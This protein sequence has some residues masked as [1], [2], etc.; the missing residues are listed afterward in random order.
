MKLKIV[1]ILL[2]ALILCYIGFMNH[3][4]LVYPDTGTY[5][6]SGFSGKVPMERTIFYGLFMRHVSL[7]SSPWLII[8]AQGAFV[9]YLLYRTFGL[10]FTGKRR[11]SLFLIALTLLTLTTGLS[12]NVSI[13]LPDIFS[14]IAV[15]CLI[16]LLFQN[17]LKKAEFVIL[18]ILFIFSIAVHL[19]SVPIL[20]LLLPLLLWLRFKRNS[21]L[22]QSVMPAR[23]LLIC[24]GLLVGTLIIV[25]SVHYLHGS[26]FQLSKG[27]HVYILNHIRETGVL[28]AYLKE[29]CH[30]RNYKICDHQDF[31]AGNFMWDENSALYK[32]GG[33][34]A[35]V[36]EYNG[37][38]R[39]IIFTPKYFVL[40]AQKGVEYSLKQVFTFNVSVAEPQLAG[41]AP[42]GQIAWRFKDTLGEYH[43]SVQNQKGLNIETRNTIQE[44][45]ILGSMLFLLLIILNGTVFKSLDPKMK[46]IIILVIAHSLISSAVCSNLSGVDARY[47]NRIVWLLSL[48]TFIIIA[49]QVGKGEPLWKLLIGKKDS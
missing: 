21:K 34:E 43:A 49:I 28:E 32:T 5:M 7:S 18:G 23:R 4:P 47:Q 9:S 40:L 48:L 24:F 25:P 30:E 22:D 37:I 8:L 26:T 15:L 38:I 6:D 27:S 36:G 17:N 44:F 20:L 42:Y 45:I 3:Y 29:V 14:A 13:L 1:F 33:W 2:G 10:F 31:L 19:S 11:N 39:D 12:Y 16:Q 46:W 41:S 35:N